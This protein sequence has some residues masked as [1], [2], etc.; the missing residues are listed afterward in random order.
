MNWTPLDRLKISDFRMK[1]ALSVSLATIL[2]LI[3]C[4]DR[5]D[6]TLEDAPGLIA[7]D[8][9]LDNRMV[10]QTIR[11][12]QTQVYFDNTDPV[13]VSGAQVNLTNSDGTVYDFA[14]QPDGSYQWFPNNE[15]LNGVGLSFVLNIAI[16]GTTYSSESVMNPVPPIDSITFRFEEE[17]FIF[18]DS[19]WAE[20]WSRDILGTGNTYWIKSYKNGQLLNNPDEINI[21]FDAGFTEG[22]NVDGLL[23][24][25]PI[26]DAI[27]PFE[28][29][30]DDEFLSPFDDGDHI[31]VELY[32]ITREAFIFLNELALQINR[33]GGFAE[34]FATPLSNVPTNIVSSD[35][36]ERVVGFFNISAVEANEAVLD[37]SQVPRD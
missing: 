15:P 26:R 31:R 10:P 21:A 35:P 23:F 13:N 11:V 19:Y 2:I 30:D 33:P 29:D 16:N 8:A 9:W 28:E 12:T 14:E 18:P 1:M 4:E 7:V 20:F 32:S 17:D 36:N 6:P 27:N 25:P 34:L 37:T 5:I 24:I 3:G 22:G